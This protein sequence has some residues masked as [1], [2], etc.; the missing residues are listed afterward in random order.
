[1]FCVVGLKR[2]SVDTARPLEF[3][4]K[5]NGGGQ[6]DNGRFIFHCFCGFNCGFHCIDVMITVFD[7]LRM[8]SFPLITVAEGAVTHRLRNVSRH[9]RWKRLSLIKVEDELDT[10]G[11]PVDGNMVIIVNHN[12]ISQLQMSGKRGS[13]TSNTFLSTSIAKVTISMVVYPVNISCV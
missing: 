3:W 8:P 11:I 10:S 5:A 2:V 4:A 1:M 13:F 9:P 6:F 12:Q 7:V